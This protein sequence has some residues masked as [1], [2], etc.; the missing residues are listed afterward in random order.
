MSEQVE[1]HIKKLY[2]IED[3]LG[4]GAYG[5]V[6]RARKRSSGCYIA[7]KKIFDA[8]Q[9][10]TDAQRTYR[11]VMYLRHLNSHSNIIKLHNVYPSM[12][13]RDLYLSFELMES[14]LHI[15]SRSNVLTSIQKKRIM[16]QLLKAV[17]YLHSADLVHRDLKPSNVL[18]DAQ[19]NVK[20]ADF[21]LVRSI[22]EDNNDARLLSE[23]IATKWYRAPELI[24]G[25]KRYSK[26]IDMWAAGCVM[27]ELYTGRPLFAGKGSL[28]QIEVISALLGRPSDKDI[29]DMKVS[30]Y[31]EYLRSL[32]LNQKTAFEGIF[33]TH[34]PQ[35]LDLIRCLLK[36]SPEARYTV[37]EALEHAYFKQIRCV[38]EERVCERKIDL[39]INDDHQ[40][41]SKTYRET[42]FDICDHK[43][44]IRRPLPLKQLLLPSINSNWKQARGG[45]VATLN[46]P[47]DAA[48]PAFGSS[49]LKLLFKNRLA[50]LN[51]L[52][53][54]LAKNRTASKLK[55]SKLEDKSP[56]NN[57]LD[58]MKMVQPKVKV[59]NENS[60]F[61]L[62]NDKKPSKIEN[63]SILNAS[64][65]KTSTNVRNNTIVRLEKV[66]VHN[67]G[68]FECVKVKRRSYLPL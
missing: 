17:K 61:E 60:R 51:C 2:A 33:Y 9:N 34:E 52:S 16:Y 44:L 26:A 27:A 13:K 37:E 25:C 28:N 1:S 63:R 48:K 11:E 35:A 55:N 45:R 20:L 49:S 31:V 46:T 4:K 32:D 56:K 38:E 53:S 65:N 50:S 29:R 21:G 66:P 62:R 6:W 36:Y 14:D 40:L 67:K 58:V 54:H 5:V 41:S 10:A 18:L 3:K 57:K 39:P 64:V 22:T 30:S 15:A 8:F 23:H 24:L 47:G 43:E 7:L 19:Y 12:N 42:L 59:A 68:M